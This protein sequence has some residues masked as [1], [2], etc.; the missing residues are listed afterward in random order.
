M[1]LRTGWLRVTACA[2][3]TASCTMS[4]QEAPPLT[5]PSEF[6][7]S[8]TVGATPDVLPTDGGSQSLVTITAFDSNGSPLRN[9]TLRSEIQVNGV[10]A[11]FGT[12]SARNVVTDSSGRASVVYTA[13]LIQGG[14]DTGTVV[15]I[16]VTPMGSN[17]ANAVTRTTSIRLV[18]SGVVVPPD[19]L[20]AAFTFTPGSPLESQPVFFD[21]T[22]SKGTAV[23][24]IVSYRW[25]FGDG[26]FANGPTISYAFDTPGTYTVKLTIFDALG[27]SAFTT[28][29][30]SVGQS[31]RPTAEFVFSPTDPLTNQAVNFNASASVA[32]AG[33]RI[34]SYTWDFGDG[35]PLVTSGVAI[36]SHGY[37]VPRTYTVT[38]TVT[39]DIGRTGTISK[40][41]AVK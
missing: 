12:L 41:V 39:D 26:G 4:K 15:D 29:S 27:R 22:S 9:V 36:T 20:Q 7:T 35:T 8:I 33:R 23:N 38:L 19:G 25:D 11:D 13:P 37:G 14:V 31:Q 21:A 10:L 24:P 17:Y 18:P 1:K 5:G 28:R 6:G 30:V 32:T 40:T 34:V 3:I 16:G 2:A